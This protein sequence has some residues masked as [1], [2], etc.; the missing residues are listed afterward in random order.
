MEV[1]MP[2]FK[3]SH[4]PLELNV[5]MFMCNRA[6]TRERSGIRRFGRR[7]RTRSLWR[8]NHAHAERGRDVRRERLR[9]G[10]QKRQRDIEQEA[11]F[12]DISFWRSEQVI[13]QNYVLSDVSMCIATHNAK[14]LTED[15]LEMLS[16]DAL[17]GPLLVATV[18][19]V[20]E[21]IGSHNL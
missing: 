6:R 10:I 18:T 7:S 11:L 13:T 17:A 19:Y 3:L 12:F 8:E 20:N 9:E 16:I 21:Q 1:N 5:Q 15:E 14:P 4:L 2:N